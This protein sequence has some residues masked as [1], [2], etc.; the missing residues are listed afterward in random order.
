MCKC[1]PKSTVTS[2]GLGLTV[3]FGLLNVIC[4]VISGVDYQ[5]TDFKWTS[6]G[7]WRHMAALQVSAA[8]VVFVIFLLGLANFT[9]GAQCK[10]IQLV[11]VLFE[12]LTTFFAL[13]VAIYALVGA[14]IKTDDFTKVC[15]KNYTGIFTDFKVIDELMPIV[16]GLLCSDKCPCNMTSNYSSIE[17]FIDFYNEKRELLNIDEEVTTEADLSTIMKFSYDGAINI[18]QCIEQGNVSSTEIKEKFRQNTKSDLIKTDE[19]MKDFMTFWG[20]IEK[21]FDCN[22]W[23]EVLYPDTDDEDKTK[24]LSKY[25]FSDVTKGVVRNRGCMHRLIDWLPKVINAYGSVLLIIGVILIVVFVLA[26]SL[27]CDCHV[28]GSVFPVEERKHVNANK[29]EENLKGTQLVQG[30]PNIEL[31]EVDNPQ[32]NKEKEKEKPNEEDQI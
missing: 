19:Q 21:K 25:L 10:T 27:L 24:I 29:E 9:V 31:K 2:M 5:Q 17:D 3:M 23:C 4:I 22:G 20:R 11:F 30:G 26:I 6:I 1:L 13:A 15:H 18:Q 14:A 16:D 8:V 28:E 7:P 12:L 32:E